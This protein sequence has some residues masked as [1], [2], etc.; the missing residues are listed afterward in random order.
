MGLNHPMSSNPKKKGMMKE[1]TFGE[2]RVVLPPF[3]LFAVD[4]SEAARKD[5]SASPIFWSIVRSAAKTS[6]FQ[7]CFADTGAY[8]SWRAALLPQCPSL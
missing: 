4:P 8:I 2:R 6:V 7:Y 1:A 5:G 3:T